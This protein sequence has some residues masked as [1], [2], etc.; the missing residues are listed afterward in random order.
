MPGD[1]GGGVIPVPI[2]N[3]EVKPSNVNGTA[4]SRCGRVESRQAFFVQFLDLNKRQIIE[5]MPMKDFTKNE[6]TAKNVNMVQKTIDV[7]SY[8]ANNPK[9]AKLVK[10]ANDLGYAKTT[11]HDILKTLQ[12]NN[13]TQY[14]YPEKKVYIIGSRVY[15]MGIIY[16]ESS[17][18][19]RIA[20]PYLT[21]LADKYAK[22]A[23]ISRRS[24]DR[25]FCIYKYAPLHA[26]ASS[27]TIGDLKR[28]HSTSIGKCY[29]AFDPGATQMIETIDLPA[30][31]PYTI[32]SRDELRKN[33]NDI[34]ERGYS[35]EQRESHEL[36]ACVAAPL[37]NKGS[38]IA[39]ISITGL[40]KK[41]E[42]LNLQG[43]EIAQ[44]ARIISQQLDEYDPIAAG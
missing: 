22:A 38:M 18:L 29:L 41:E 1:N 25:A 24:N 3:T 27:G 12:E 6:T 34:R 10:I 37:Y 4:S 9:G 32:T 14:V 17:N 5:S 23:F 40:Y 35:W 44:L 31:T 16:L 7:L 33:I 39:T 8:L 19:L 21:L 30:F 20:K 13:F 42:D 15:T 36:M 2:P 43:N 26:N 11:V 28:L